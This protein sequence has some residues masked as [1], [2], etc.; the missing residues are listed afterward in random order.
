[1][2]KYILSFVLSGVLLISGCSIGIKQS[3]DV[4]VMQE[5]ETALPNI[6]LSTVEYIRKALN[7]PDF[8][9]ISYT[10][11]MPEYNSDFGCNAAH[12]SF[13]ENGEEIACVSFTPEE[14]IFLGNAMY[15]ADIT[16][17]NGLKYYKYTN[18]RYGYSIDVPHFL[19]IE[20]FPTNG[21]GVVFSSYDNSL[22]LTVDGYHIFDD[23]SDINS[24]YN[25]FEQNYV[26]YEPT[27]Q[28]L[29]DNWFVFTG[30]RDG[31]IVYEKHYVKSDY[32]HN[33]F[34]ISY[35]E[36]RREKYY[37]MVTHVAYS[38]KTGIGEDSPVAD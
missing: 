20:Y 36:S 34:Y 26:D 12:I 2:K 4:P 33:S 9:D 17:D 37:D 7:V 8:G 16:D 29:K 24:Y 31:E 3:E 5:T 25:Y 14:T 27:Y 15:Y 23:A 30:Y 19:K 13:A 10:Y 18:S 38:F 35:P 11:T 1:M 28:R 21:A 6:D 32:T 22:T